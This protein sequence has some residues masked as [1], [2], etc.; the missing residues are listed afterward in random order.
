M[1]NDMDLY[2]IEP[3]LSMWHCGLVAD[4]LDM[5]R[6]LQFR[7]AKAP[8][9]SGQAYVHPFTFRGFDLYGEFEGRLPGNARRLVIA[10]GRWQKQYDVSSGVNDRG[11][12]SVA[13]LSVCEQMLEVHEPIWSGVVGRDGRKDDR[14]IAAELREV[15]TAATHSSRRTDGG[16]R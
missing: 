13:L 4:I 15:A 1:E 3:E 8:A 14:L 11:N 12:S 9:K 16:A 10:Q 5:S 6:I 7:L 2:D